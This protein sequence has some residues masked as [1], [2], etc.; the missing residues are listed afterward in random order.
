M[1][2]EFALINKP[3]VRSRSKYHSVTLFLESTH[4]FSHVLFSRKHIVI[5][6]RV[7]SGAHTHS[8]THLLKSTF[9]FGHTFTQEHIAIRSRFSREHIYVQLRISREFIVIQPI[10][11]ESTDV[12]QHI[13]LACYSYLHSY[14]MFTAWSSVF[15]LRVH[16]WNCSSHFFESG[17]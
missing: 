5:L 2:Y 14:T 1:S 13:V 16:R 3:P 15:Y 6:A 9:P 12:H 11:Y 7:F 17:L 8:V 10:T 4:S